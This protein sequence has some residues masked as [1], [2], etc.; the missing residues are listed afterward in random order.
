[1]VISL[2]KRQEDSKSVVRRW[3]Y[4]IICVMTSGVGV[5]GSDQSATNKNKNIFNLQ[6]D[7]K[8]MTSVLI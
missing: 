8:C 7:M 3:E 1:M 4:I 6:F 5:G 2:A